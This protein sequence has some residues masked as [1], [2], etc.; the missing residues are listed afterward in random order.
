[1]SPRCILCEGLCPRRFSVRGHDVH[2]CAGCDLEFVWPTPSPDEIDAVYRANYFTGPGAGYE[3]YFAREREIAARK[4]ATRLDR[5]AALG[6]T[7]GRVLDV[8][9]AAG[10]FLEAAQAR[11]FSVAGVELSAEARA[12]AA[13]AL[14]DRIVPTL[15]DVEGTFDVI[16]LWDVL[17][18]LPAPSDALAELVPRLA[19]GGV[20]GVVIPVLGSVNTRVAPRTWDQYKPPEHLWFFSPAALRA[21]LARHGLAVAHEEPA[22]T[23]RARFIDPEGRRRDLATRALRGLDALACGALARIGGEALRVDS[24]AFFARRRAP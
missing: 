15:S 23:R 21:L 5:L 18:H 10:Y 1:M 9:C 4:A 3:D 6:V 12:Q 14:R 20:L 8:G 19:P 11:G 13:A 16:T 17:E 2:R 7:R 24:M 22:W